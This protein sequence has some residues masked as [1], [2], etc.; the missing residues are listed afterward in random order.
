MKSALAVDHELSQPR[1][2]QAT[3]GV[4]KRDVDAPLLHAQ[5]DHDYVFSVWR[6]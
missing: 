4:A 6:E 1:H 5:K 2:P 3:P